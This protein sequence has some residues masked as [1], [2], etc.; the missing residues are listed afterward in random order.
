MNHH[1]PKTFFKKLKETC[2]KIDQDVNEVKKKVYDLPGNEDLACKKKETSE[3]KFCLEPKLAHI[4]DFIQY[5]KELTTETE[6][7]ISRHENYLQQYG[8]KPLE[9]APE[10]DPAPVDNIESS[11]VKVSSEIKESVSTTPSLLDYGLVSRGYSGSPSIT[12]DRKSSLE[13]L[14][15]PKKVEL[16]ESLKTQV[17]NSNSTPTLEI[18]GTNTDKETPQTPTTAPY[19]PDFPCTPTLVL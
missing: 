5:F 7:S 8:Y 11:P 10:S 14:I 13:D 6:A 9:M 16:T 17:E 12:V 15:V 1:Q 4:A 2:R 19:I 3:L 18:N